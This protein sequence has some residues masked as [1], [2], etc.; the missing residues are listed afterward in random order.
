ML[1]TVGII[2]ALV[3]IMLLQVPSLLKNKMIKETWIF[4]LLMLFAT[5]IMIG[6]IHDYPIPN[7]LDLIGWCMEPL[8]KLFTWIFD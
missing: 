7:P 3:V 1:V 5:L 2:I 4:S 8:N 6:N